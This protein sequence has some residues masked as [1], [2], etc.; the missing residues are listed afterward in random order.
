MPIS[1][2][3]RSFF[4]IRQIDHPNLIFHN[5]IFHIPVSY[6]KQENGILAE[7]GLAPE[8]VAQARLAGEQFLKVHL[9]VQSLPIHTARDREGTKLGPISSHPL[10]S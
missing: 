9:H 1:Y 7:F 10:I 6:I 8:G 5:L 2:A 4:L 3:L